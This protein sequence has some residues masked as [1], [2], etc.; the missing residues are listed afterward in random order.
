MV[1]TAS[2]RP[3]NREARGFLASLV[4]TALAAVRDVYFA[5]MFQQVSPLLVGVAAFSL[6]AIVFL[7]IALAA[8]PAGVVRLLRRPRELVCVNVT[9]ALA[10]ISF[11]YA[12]RTIEP[13]LVQVLFSGIGPLTIVWWDGGD[14][15]RGERVGHLGLLVTIV[16]A[17]GVA[18]AGLSGGARQPFLPALLGVALAIF[19]GFSI[20]VS[21]VLSRQLND[22]GVDP[23]ALVA[24][25]F[26]GATLLAAAL[27]LPAGESLRALGARE[28]IVG[29]IG[30]SLLLVVAPIYVNQVGIALASPLTVRVALAVGPVLIFVLQLVEGRLSSSPYSLTCAVLYGVVAVT[31]AVLRRR[32]I[33]RGLQPITHPPLGWRIWPVR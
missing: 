29:V 14:R 18:L 1:D 8:S 9:T 2:P 27:M 25:R 3:R 22:A 17:G 15:S 30:A 32:A 24:L 11:F 19:A 21:T 6:C 16:L 12:L 33:A 7:P 20:S 23:T 10:W 28:A 4:F 31:G 26:V 5:G 13:L